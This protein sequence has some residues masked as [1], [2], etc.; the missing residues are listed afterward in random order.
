MTTKN[1]LHAL[2]SVRSACHVVVPLQRRRRRRLCTCVS[3]LHGGVDSKPSQRGLVKV[4]G[5]DGGGR[6]RQANE[7]RVG[8]EV[9]AGKRGE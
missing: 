4:P 5:D 1:A 8:D 3:H 2:A 9:H 7:V 6:R